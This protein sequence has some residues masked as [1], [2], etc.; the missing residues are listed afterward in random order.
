MTNLDSLLKRRDIT[1]LTKVWLV[2]TMVFPVVIYRCDS[3]TIK[4]AEYWRIDALKKWCWKRLFRVPWTT[5]SNQATLNIH[6]RTDAKAKVPIL[7]SPTVKSWLIGKDPDAGKDWAKEEKWATGDE[8][9]GW[10]QRL[11]GHEF[12][13]ALWNSEGQISL[14]CCSPWGHKESEKTKR[15]HSNNQKTK[16]L[17]F[18]VD[19]QGIGS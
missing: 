14:A 15:P 2:K 12:E 9:V 11:N 18:L 4:K 13:Q 10:H 7:W 5:R 1:L 3:C 8:M 6:S 16:C 19:V 17:R